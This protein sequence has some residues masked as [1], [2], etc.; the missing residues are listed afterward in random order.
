ML[1]KIKGFTLI[2]LMVVVAILGILTSIV[3]P[4]FIAWRERSRMMED[5]KIPSVEQIITTK[6]SE[7]AEKENGLP[8]LK[9]K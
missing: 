1:R 5:K 3:I 4:N 2:E 7:D 6:P 9:I 8:S